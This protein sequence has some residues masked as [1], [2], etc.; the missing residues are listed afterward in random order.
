[1]KAHMV[2]NILYGNNKAYKMIGWKGLTIDQM[3]AHPIGRQTL[4]N[5]ISELNNKGETILNTNIPKEL[6]E[7]FCI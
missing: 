6:L 4:I 5:K 1:M 7:I 3:L 2:N